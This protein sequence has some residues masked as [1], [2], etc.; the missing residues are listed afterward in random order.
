[1]KK[2]KKMKGWDYMSLSLSA[3]AGLGLEAVFAFLLEPILYGTDM[4]H[5]TPMQTIIH[6][7]L[8][9]I[10]WGIIAFLLIKASK[11]KYQFDLFSKQEKMKWWQW[12]FVTLCILYSVAAS[13]QSWNGFKVLIEF[14]KR[15]PL[16]FTFQYVYYLVE[17]ILFMLIIVFAQ[18][19]FEVWFKKKN[20]PFGGIICGITWGFA[21]AFTKGSIWIGLEGIVLGFMLGIAYLLVNRDIKKTYIVMLLMFII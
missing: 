14:Q 4:N 13:Y 9:C 21:H 8:T 16:L 12:F 11:N 5:F 2:D 18:K 1:M 3:F 19:A 20:I 7:T 17:T 10:T 15:G 6:W